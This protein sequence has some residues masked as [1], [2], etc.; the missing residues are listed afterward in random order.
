MSHVREQWSCPKCT[1][2]NDPVFDQ[3]EMCETVNPS[4]ARNRTRASKKKVNTPEVACSSVAIIG[5]VD[6]G[7]TET[8]NDT[9]G[10][11]EAVDMCSFTSMKAPRV[12]DES[13]APVAA[14]SLLS[15]DEH[16]AE[17]L[18][19]IEEVAQRDYSK[20]EVEE[21]KRR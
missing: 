8:T 16:S 18:S 21:K 1:Y 15:S 10:K 19:D 6:M 9:Y 12:K 11:K 13:P 2:L 17:C 7:V 4:A 14:I 3:C 5:D 20:A